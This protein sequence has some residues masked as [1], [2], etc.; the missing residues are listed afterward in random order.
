VH[1]HSTAIDRRVQ[2]HVCAL[3]LLLTGPHVP[4]AG[5]PPVLLLSSSELYMFHAPD[6]AAYEDAVRAR[7]PPKLA[8]RL[9]F[10]VHAQH[11]HEGPD[12]SGMTHPVNRAYFAYLIDVMANVAVAALQQ[13]VPATLAYGERMFGFGQEDIRDP[14]ILDRTLHVLRAYPFAQPRKADPNGSSSRD[15][16][17]SGAGGE[18]RPLAT[19][20]HWTMHPQVTRETEFAV[21]E[22]NCRAL[23]E[24]P[25]CSARKQFLTGDFPGILR[26]QLR[27]NDPTKAGTHDPH[28]RTEACVCA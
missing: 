7:V 8:A 23:G 19:I 2:A 24:P 16:S 17:S 5:T 20:V 4:D 12:T 25:G 9:R 26:R 22:A 1:I 11:N 10:L 3:R 15:G 21:P 18:A 13:R 27:G 6:I 28:M 14:V